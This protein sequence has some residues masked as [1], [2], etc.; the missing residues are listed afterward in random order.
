VARR[1]FNSIVTQARRDAFRIVR[2]EVRAALPKGWRLWLAV[3]WGMT[4]YDDAGKARF[5]LYERADRLPQGV[6]KACLLAAD[7]VETFGE[8]NTVIEGAR[9][10]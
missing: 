6:R 3:G 7:F 4:L 8:D 9:R 5:G 10:R 1:E 2:R